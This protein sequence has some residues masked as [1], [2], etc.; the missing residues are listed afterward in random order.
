MIDLMNYSD[1]LEVTLGS[2]KPKSDS[3][4]VLPTPL[5]V[6]EEKKVSEFTK[7]KLKIESEFHWEKKK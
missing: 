1:Q 6:V 4:V 5:P 7:L 3:V 2:F